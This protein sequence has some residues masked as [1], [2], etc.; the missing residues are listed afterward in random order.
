MTLHSICATFVG[1]ISQRITKVRA[2][3]VEVCQKI[4]RNPDEIILI[5]V[6]KYATA[7]HIKEAIDAGLTDVGE[8]RVQDAKEKFSQLGESLKSVRKHL[9]GHLQSNKAKLAVELFDL[10]QS[11]DSAKLMQE[12][13]KEA[14]KKNKVMD[15]L[16]QVNTAHDENKFGIDPE[17]VN[18][19]INAVP[20][21]KNIRVRGLMTI[22]AMTEDADA[23]RKSFK[24]LKTLFDRIKA[25]KSSDKFQMDYLSMGMSGDFPIAIEE[26]A[27]L[28]RVGSA[29]FQ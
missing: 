20:S 29:I 8:N 23:V 16:I 12:I 24:D 21:M 10:I 3:I 19:I 28:V 5:G 15:I 7:A 11:V 25:E 18:E 6:T 1:V 9:I 13:D 4:G 22:A 26:G 27:N 14:G 2:K 17:S